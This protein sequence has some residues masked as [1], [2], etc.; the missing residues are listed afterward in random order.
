MNKF[1]KLLCQYLIEGYTQYE[2]ANLLKE[3]GIVPNSLS[4][5]EKEIKRLKEIHKAKTMCH[6]GAILTLKK[7][8][9]RQ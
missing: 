9:R 3:A 6:L 5:I 2:I 4:S 1:T 8:I 7:Y